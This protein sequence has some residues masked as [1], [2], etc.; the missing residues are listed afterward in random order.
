MHTLNIINLIRW[1][2]GSADRLICRRSKEIIRQAIHLLVDKGDRE[3]TGRIIELDKKNARSFPTSASRQNG[4][5]FTTL[6]KHVY[7]AVIRL[8]LADS[9]C[10]IAGNGCGTVRTKSRLLSVHFWCQ[11]ARYASRCATKPRSSTTDLAFMIWKRSADAGSL[12]RLKNAMILLKNRGRARRS[13]MPLVASSIV[14]EGLN[15]PRIWSATYGN[16][17]LSYVWARYD[18]ESYPHRKKAADNQFSGL[19]ERQGESLIEGG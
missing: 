5:S 1:S 8:A 9:P 19:Q 13:R 17:F 2:K 18:K 16:T 6:N 12:P 11:A 7:P 14:S 10:L 3:N 4:F 15:W